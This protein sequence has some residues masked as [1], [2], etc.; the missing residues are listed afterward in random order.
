VKTNT[1]RHGKG[2]SL[3]RRAFDDVVS[4]LLKVKA[5]DTSEKAGQK[6]ETGP[7]KARD[8]ARRK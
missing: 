2:V 5:A 1:D 7:S 6:T 4:D 3:Y 8:R